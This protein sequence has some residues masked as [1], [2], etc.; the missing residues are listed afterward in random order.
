MGKYKCPYCGQDSYA[1]SSK[2]NGYYKNW[3]AVA[4]HT[5]RCSKSDKAFAITESYGP[6]HYTAF[7]VFNTKEELLA[8]YPDLEFRYGDYI[9]FFKKYKNIDISFKYKKVY[10]SNTNLINVI[11]EFVNIH[12]RIP[13]ARD[14]KGTKP[15]YSNF[16]TVF[17]TWNN[18]IE[19]AG[20]EPN[21]QNGYG[22]DTF[23]L[24]GH[25]YR[26]RAEAYFAD[27]FLYDKYTYV[28]EPKYP[29][30]V[31]MYD[32]YIKDLD[33]YIE[34]DGGLRP[35]RIAEKI[36]MNKQLHRK[37]LVIPISE[38]YRTSLLLNCVQ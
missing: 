27:N 1:K 5:S 13:A 15:N 7:L 10:Y 31:W 35:E 12:N 33:L 16:E 25:L 36:E 21:I 6:I 28:I 14:F 26:S 17:G 20:F 34:L 22:I 32:W 8:V 23:G 37:C 24:D 4:R 3:K 18:A 38:I 9:K 29:N 11:K 2:A 30:G 19:A